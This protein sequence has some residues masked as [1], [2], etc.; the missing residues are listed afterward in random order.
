MAAAHHFEARHPAAALP[1]DD[2]QRAVDALHEHVDI[3]TRGPLRL[4]NYKSIGRLYIW[5]TTAALN[6]E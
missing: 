1:Y 6:T 4:Y 3:K 5:H 2:L